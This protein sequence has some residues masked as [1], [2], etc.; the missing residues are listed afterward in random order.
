MDFHE[1][2]RLK[3][4]YLQAYVMRNA[5]ILPLLNIKKEN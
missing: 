5:I 3:T 4:F 1:N 2:L